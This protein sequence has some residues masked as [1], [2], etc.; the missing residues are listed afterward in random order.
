MH[1]LYELVASPV[2]PLQLVWALLGAEQSQ[3]FMAHQCIKEYIQA[4]SIL[5]CEPH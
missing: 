4:D 5:I 3:Y 1:L 2:S